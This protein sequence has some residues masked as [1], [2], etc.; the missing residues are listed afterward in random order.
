MIKCT[1]VLLRGEKNT[2]Y[3]KLE[4]KVLYGSWKVFFLLVG[5][6]RYDFYCGWWCW[7]D[8]LKE[9]ILG[10]WPKP[11]AIKQKPKSQYLESDH[12]LDP[13]GSKKLK[14]IKSWLLAHV[15][16]CTQILALIMFRC[17][18]NREGRIPQ[19]QL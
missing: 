10:T 11:L 5:L 3:T 16:P 1:L 13:K 12:D 4:L 14:R 7:H 8:W 2:I 17:P 9:K 19:F 6:L 15:M 18:G